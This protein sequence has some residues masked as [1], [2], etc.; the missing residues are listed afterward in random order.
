MQQINNGGPITITHPEVSRYFMTIEESVH[1]LIRAA[2]NGNT[3]ETLILKMGEPILIKSI[4]DKLIRSSGKNI[5]IEY[6]SL[7]PGEKLAEILIGSNEIAIKTEDD[8]IL[9]ITVNPAYLDLE[10]K[11]WE[12]FRIKQHL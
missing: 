9:K 2:V 12:D 3:G 10:L 1:L 6:S 11:D 5:L 8:S 4:A 7:R